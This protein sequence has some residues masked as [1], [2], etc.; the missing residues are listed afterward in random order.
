VTTPYL[1][2]G[3]RT[4]LAPRLWFGAAACLLTG[5]LGAAALLAWPTGGPADGFS[6]QTLLNL[7]SILPEAVVLGALVRL[8]TAV[9][10]PGLRRSSMCLFVSIWLMMLLRLFALRRLG[11]AGVVVVV[12]SL[13]VALAALT[14]RVWFG[15]ALLRSRDRLGGV[16]AVLGWLELLLAAS[17][18]VFRVLLMASNEPSALDQ[19][20]RLRGLASIVINNLL[21]FLLFLWFRDRLIGV[22]SA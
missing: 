16:A 21:L 22:P 4:S 5:G 2:D 7:F 14:F 6:A 1:L 13:V 11:E 10:S 9:H 18:L 20:D 15:V 19:A 3:E 12:L 17:W 8:A